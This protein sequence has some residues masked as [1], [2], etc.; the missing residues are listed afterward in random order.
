MMVGCDEVAGTG[1][2]LLVQDEPGLHSLLSDDWYI[3]NSSTWR[4]LNLWVLGKAGLHSK[5]LVSHRYTTQWDPASKK[6]SCSLSLVI[7]EKN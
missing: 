2:G 6:N 1:V 5:L 4:L 3:F 7:R